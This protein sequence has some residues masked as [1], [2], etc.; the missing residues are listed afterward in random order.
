M[1]RFILTYNDANNEKRV[2]LFK[3][4]AETKEYISLLRSCGS[5]SYNNFEIKIVKPS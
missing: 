1:V 4:L 5:C 3:T 2:R